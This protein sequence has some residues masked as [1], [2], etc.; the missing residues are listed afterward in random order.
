MGCYEDHV[1]L[2]YLD[3]E[4]KSEGMAV[5]SHLQQCEQ[6]QARLRAL[7]D[8]EQY[9]EGVLSEHL[10]EIELG[11]NFKEES[12]I[13][14]KFQL[15]AGRRP[16]AKS[17][18]SGISRS[19]RRLAAAAVVLLLIGGFSLGS[20]RGVV[21]DLLSVFRVDRIETIAISPQEMDQIDEAVR[22]GIGRIEIDNLGTFR[23]DGKG[24]TVWD[25]SLAEA[26]KKL[27]FRIIKPAL[28]GYGEP[29]V[30]IK[31]YPSQSLTLNVP[32]IN[33]MIRSLGGTKLL[34]RELDKQT[35]TLSA[36]PQMFLNYQSP[37]LFPVSIVQM[38][39]PQLVV[40]G[41]VKVEEVRDTLLSLP[42]W[43]EGIRQQL[44]GIN[45]WRNTMVI[46]TTADIQP[47]TVRGYQGVIWSAHEPSPD[48]AS[49]TVLW[50]ENGVIY[51]VSAPLAREQVLEI[52]EGMK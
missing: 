19:Q 7:A 50:S 8:D 47:V 52:A 29:Q 3:G 5:E 18:L 6:C 17:K 43:P 16:K 48:A 12:W 44:A 51:S 1:L 21:A 9:V 27:D 15:N 22:K 23:V 28:E 42:F 46:P 10:E 34:P 35:I 36:P 25:G 38:K 14:L 40:P 26:Q 33:E 45:D 20:V 39:S 37:G 2:A 4:L 31:E 13:R 41:N 32:G 30:R 24:E 49:T 11:N